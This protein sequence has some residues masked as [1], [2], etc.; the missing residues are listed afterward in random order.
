M[1]FNITDIAFFAAPPFLNKTFIVWT[2]CAAPLSLSAV[3]K[4]IP[5]NVM[6]HYCSN[7]KPMFDTQSETF[8][9]IY[10]GLYTS[11]ILLQINNSH[12]Y[13]VMEKQAGV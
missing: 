2:V 4:R 13:E 5:H 6:G 12:M 9:V 1:A 11:S 3:Q 7:I 8:W 10:N